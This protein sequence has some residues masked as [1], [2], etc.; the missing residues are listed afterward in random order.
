MRSLVLALCT[1]ARRGELCALRW[2][3]VDLDNAAMTIAQCVVRTNARFEFKGT[4][5]G[6]VRTVPLNGLAVATLRAHRARQNEERLRM[7]ELYANAGLVFANEL[8]QPWN[9][10]SITNAFVRLARATGISTTRLHDVRH[11]AAT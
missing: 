7:G 5:T 8:G 1:G 4:K 11:S 10:D 2:T 3:S 6:R 9:P